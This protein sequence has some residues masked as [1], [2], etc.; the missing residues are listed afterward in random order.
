MKLS[1]VVKYFNNTPY[2]CAYTGDLMGYGQLDVWDDSKRDGL[3][4]QRRIFEVDVGSPMPSRGVI[5]FEGDHWLVGFLNKDLFQGRVHREKYVLHQA[6]EEV[7]YRSIKEHL[8]DAE[9]VGIFAARVWIKTTSQVEISSEKF[10]QMQ[11]FT[12][13]S[14]PVEV[15]D[16]FTFSS[17][18]YIVTE[19]YPSTAGHQVSICE[20]LDK[21]ALEVGVVSDEVYDPI[22][23][24]M[25][26][27]DKPIKVFKLRWQSHFDYLSLATPN[28]ERGDIQGATL[29]QLETGTVLTLSNVRWRVNHVQQREGVY[30][31]HLRRA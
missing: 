4:V 9:G 11:V 30:F 14:E 13:R 8:E 24:T 26:T 6:E 16:V 19:V 31:H 28:F 18:Q 17:K 23:E 21:G 10:N 5:T 2:Y 27:T 20:E 12:S 3:T 15:G 25:Q 7:D 22:T 1:N 29:T